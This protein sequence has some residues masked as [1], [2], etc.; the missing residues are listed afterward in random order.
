MFASIVSA[1][2]AAAVMYLAWRG[3]ASRRSSASPSAAAPSSRERRGHPIALD[4]EKK[5]PMKLVEKKVGAC[6]TF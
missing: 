6:K 4:P 1:L 5:I 2:V 3:F